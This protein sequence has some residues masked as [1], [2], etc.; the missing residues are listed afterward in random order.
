MIV[1]A[2][3]ATTKLAKTGRGTTAPLTSGTP[4][5]ER[6]PGRVVG[7]CRITKPFF[8][9]PVIYTTY[10]RHDVRPAAAADAD[11]R[12]RQGRTRRRPEAY[13]TGFGP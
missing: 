1:D 8:W 10:T 6:P 9:Q 3:E 12:A 13:A 7:L 2:A 4:G 5:G 11:V